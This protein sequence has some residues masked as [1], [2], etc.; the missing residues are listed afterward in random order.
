MI[1]ME[2]NTNHHL[3]RR[4]FS[5]KDA[6]THVQTEDLFRTVTEEEHQ[7]LQHTLLDMYRDIAAVCDQYE[8]IPFLVGGSALGAVR[9]QGFIP[10]DDDLDIGMFRSDYEKF[11]KIFRK[12]LSDKYILN[13]PNYSRNPK[14]RFP[15]IIKKGTRLREIVDVK[16]DR[17]NGVFLDIFIIE[18]VPKGK[19]H[20]LVKGLLCNSLEFISGQVF[21]YEN[22]TPEAMEFYLRA[23]NRLFQM[24]RM[25]GWLFSFRSASSWFCAVDKAAR[26]RKK[27]GYLVIPTG[28]KHYFGEQLKGSVT[29]AVYL[30]F[31]KEQV[32]IFHNYNSYLQNLYGDYMKVPDEKDR[33]KHFIVELK[34]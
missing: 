12:E 22:L 19:L 4:L 6:F 9:H 3:L 34:I 33:E 13:A 32:P 20:R 16:D 31:C 10:W 24:R 8:I 5:A 26:H 17:L 1:E 7:V 11:K 23:G 2:K 21:L 29:P 15:K 25:V 28:R 14:A 18:N 30:D 27:T